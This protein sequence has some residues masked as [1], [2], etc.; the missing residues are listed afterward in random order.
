MLGWSQAE[1]ARRMGKN[2]TYLCRVL[3]GQITSWPMW[4][5]AWETTFV[6]MAMT[7]GKPGAE[8][9]DSVSPQEHA[10]RVN[11]G[12]GDSPQ[13]GSPSPKSKAI[14]RARQAGR[15]LLAGRAS[16]ACR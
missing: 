16:G 2:Q 15:G 11:G 8:S 5:L 6:A 14:A 4:S 7:I 3:S 1:L 10:R 13:S 12:Q 9:T